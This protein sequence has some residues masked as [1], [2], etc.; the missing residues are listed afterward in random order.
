M[1]VCGPSRQGGAQGTVHFGLSIGGATPVDRGRVYSAGQGG[2]P[3]P[4]LCAQGSQQ[5]PG[6][7]CK[8]QEAPNHPTDPSLPEGGL[9]TGVG[10]HLFRSAVVGHGPDCLLWMLPTQRVDCSGFI[11]PTGGG[12]FRR[13]VRRVTG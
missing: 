10:G 6:R 4:Q 13:L 7:H 3:S 12:G 11:L 1:P 2:V 5:E 9:G 8:A